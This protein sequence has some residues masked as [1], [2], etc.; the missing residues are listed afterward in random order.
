[1]QGHQPLAQPHAT[2][3]ENEFELDILEFQRGLQPKD[4][5]DWVATVGE[6]LDFKG[7]PEDRWISLVDWA[8]SPM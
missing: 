2:Q 7:V 5:L 6:V 3:R 1:M 8:S 4:F